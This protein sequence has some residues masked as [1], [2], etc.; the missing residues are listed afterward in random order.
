MATLCLNILPISHLQNLS[1]YDIVYDH[2]LSAISDLQLEG[3]D[4]THPPFYH[5]TNYLNLLNEWINALCDIVK[6]HHNQTIE[7]RL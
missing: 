1:S 4:L 7:K 3:D 5:L 2:K 6:E